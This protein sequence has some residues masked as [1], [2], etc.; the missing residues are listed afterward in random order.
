MIFFRS[1]LPTGK[2]FVL[3]FL[4]LL[5]PILEVKLT[6]EVTSSDKF[7]TGDVTKLFI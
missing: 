3:S 6:E 1:L 2:L 4:T 5:S 7:Q